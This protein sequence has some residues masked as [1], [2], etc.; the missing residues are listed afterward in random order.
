LERKQQAEIPAV[1][2]PAPVAE[3]APQPTETKPDVQKT[4]ASPPVQPSSPLDEEMVTIEET[5]ITAPAEVTAKTTATTPK[6]APHQK[7]MPA[8]SASLKQAPK[9]PENKFTPSEAEN[10]S[11]FKK[12]AHR[13]L[14]RINELIGNIFGKKETQTA[15]Q[16]PKPAKQPS[17]TPGFMDNFKKTVDRVR[18]KIR[19][20]PR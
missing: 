11:A 7:A 5:P 6:K 13:F 1:A 16:Q 17:S 19:G 12:I 4:V 8:T 9:K 18:K 2:P 3:A 20:C 10:S 15:A 14:D